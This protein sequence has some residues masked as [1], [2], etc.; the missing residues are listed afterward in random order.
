LVD[1]FF[2]S[3]FYFRLEFSVSH[4]FNYLLGWQ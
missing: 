1:D 3:H 2:E 4:A